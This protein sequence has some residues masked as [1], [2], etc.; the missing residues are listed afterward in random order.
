MAISLQALGVPGLSV[1]AQPR[2]TSAARHPAGE[3]EPSKTQQAIN[4]LLRVFSYS[5][6][7]VAVA[8]TGSTIVVP[9]LGGAVPVTILSDSM[10]PSMPL[11]SLSIIKPTSPL[12]MAEIQTRSPGKIREASDYSNLSI[13]DVVAYQP[14]PRN[15]TLVI[16]RIV[17][18]SA[19][20][21]GSFSFTTKGDNN[22]VPDRDAVADFQ[23]RGV[24]WYHLPPPL[25]TI[26][27]FLN[28]DPTNHFIAVIIVAGAGYIWAL[29]L[30]WRAFRR[31][32]PG[33][34]EPPAQTKQQKRQGP[35]GPGDTSAVT[36]TQD[37]QKL[38]APAWLLHAVE[39][40]ELESAA[41]LESE[42]ELIG[43]QS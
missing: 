20:A 6:L 15:A 41:Q 43:S 32:K 22:R 36:H 42:R 30:F 29:T 37:P 33:E 39:S 9:K 8:F 13:G 25:G 14:D 34:I 18:V 27:T 26:N 38:I 11:G 12:D 40:S 2:H 31:H 16:H 17:S 19:H 23:I 35:Q 7:L 4:L 3:A 21:D 28:H 10:A 24:V 1:N 5:L